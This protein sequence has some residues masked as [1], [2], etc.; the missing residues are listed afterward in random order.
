MTEPDLY[1]ERLDI[2]RM[3]GFPPTRAFSVTDLSPGINVIHGPNESGKTTVARAINIAVHGDSPDDDRPAVRGRLNTGDGPYDVRV[4]AGQRSFLQDGDPGAELDLPAGAAADRYRLW[5]HELLQAQDPNRDFAEQILQ[6][7]RGGYDIRAARETLDFRPSPSTANISER[8]TYAA[9]QDELNELRRELTDPAESER[10]LDEL[11]RKRKELGEKREQAAALKKAETF[12]A[13]QESLDA[14]ERKLEELPDALEK[15]T[16]DEP[17]RLAELREQRDEAE[18]AIRDAR[19]AIED[20]RQE[21][22]DLDLPDEDPP[23]DLVPTLRR[24]AQK[25]RSHE[26]KIDRL[27]QELSGVQAQIEESRDALGEVTDLEALDQID[28]E[29]V[30]RADEIAQN[31][32]RLHEEQAVFEAV[33]AWLSGEE[34]PAEADGLTEAIRALRRWLQQPESVVGEDAARRWTGIAGGLLTAMAGGAGIVLAWAGAASPAVGFVGF[35]L[36]LA[37]IVLLFVIWRSRDASEA[38]QIRETYERDFR[39]TDFDPPSKWEREAVEER[40]DQ[41]QDTLVQVKVAKERAQRRRELAPDLDSLRE[42]EREVEQRVEEVREELGVA[43]E[44]SERSF[45]WFVRRLEDWQSARVERARIQGGLEDVRRDREAIAEQISASLAPYGYEPFEDAEA[46]LTQV[47][48]LEGRFGRYREATDEIDRAQ[49]KQTEAQEELEESQDSIQELFGELDLEPGDDAGLQRLCDRLEDYDEAIEER[50]E[51]KPLREEALENLRRE[52]GYVAQMEQMSQTEITAELDDLEPELEELEEL[53]DAIPR[54]KER[55]RNWKQDDEVETALEAR[56]R[57]LAEL[58]DKMEEDT[59]K[60]VGWTVADHVHERTKDQDLPSVFDRAR[61]LLA[62]FTRG[63]Y[64]LRF[65][66][67]DPPEFRALDTRFDETKALDQLSSGTRVQLLLAVR[68]AFV[69]QQEK[70]PKLPL[71]LDETLANSDDVRARAIVEAV[72]EIAR[73]GRQVFYL[74]AQKDEVAKWRSVLENGEDSDP[75]HVVIDLAAQRSVSQDA[76]DDVPAFDLPETPSEAVPGPGD[77]THEEYGKALGM[78]AFDPTEDIGA[79]HLWYVVEDPDLLHTLLDLGIERWGELKNLRAESEEIDAIIADGSWSWIRARA[80]A[81]SSFR[82][83]W[84][85]GRGK[86]VD[87]AV[88]E[89]A[90]GVTSTKIDEVAEVAESVDGDPDALLAALERGKVSYFRSAQREKLEHY[91][92]R[93]GYLDARQRLSPEEIRQ[94]TVASVDSEIE[95]DILR[96]EDVEKLLERCSKGA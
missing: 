63:R 85:V 6:E 49:E 26:E 37:G 7:T 92:R 69:E 72:V 59:A 68:L 55:I 95:A 94:R 23:E 43:F 47:E 17:D 35:G 32:E 42:R 4:E 31:A 8:Q 54:L 51:A 65:S 74:T 22:E 45:L 27:E 14:A 39:R 48:D 20:A 77:S 53:G 19:Q 24:R 15:V 3:P 12:R 84:S 16:G 78:P 61:E 2:H 70:G 82:A 81:L 66:D 46:A 96:Q 83:A 86:P 90:D 89:E 18:E 87:R 80:K 29:L 64:R 9:R 11:E 52:P 34:P 30:Q 56:D 73:D 36:V 13:H 93:E 91:L 40:L 38:S 88:L 57:A 58:R 71:L 33:E 44:L 76:D 5:L 60:V 41:I 21:L 28:T 75:P 50:S 79:T 10:R 67:A 25:L 62:T 1:L